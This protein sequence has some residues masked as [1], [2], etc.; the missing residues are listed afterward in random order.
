MNNSQ[1]SVATA[2]A[3][4]ISSGR[5]RNKKDAARTRDGYRD[6]AVNFR[7]RPLSRRAAAIR[8]ISEILNDASGKR[9][10]RLRTT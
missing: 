9:L 6:T 4:R 8:S 2:R 1:T 7:E 3:S 5:D 10:V